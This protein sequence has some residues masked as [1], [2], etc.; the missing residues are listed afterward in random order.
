MYACLRAQ[1]LALDRRPWDDLHVSPL[2][3][4]ELFARDVANARQAQQQQNCRKLPS[5][6][7][8]SLWQVLLL[9]GALAPEDKQLQKAL[10]FA[11]SVRA[12]TAAGADFLARDPPFHDHVPAAAFSGLLRQGQYFGATGS[13][14]RHGGRG[15]WPASWR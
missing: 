11:A 10:R 13:L 14:G 7:Q 5:L 15:G 3:M 4:E 1:A 2:E 12:V 6:W 8:P 9:R